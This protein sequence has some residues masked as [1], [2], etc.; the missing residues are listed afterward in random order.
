MGDF[1][2]VGVVVVVSKKRI[3]TIIVT[4]CR[5]VPTLCVDLEIQLNLI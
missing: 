1:H 5:L 3:I 4:S 2:L